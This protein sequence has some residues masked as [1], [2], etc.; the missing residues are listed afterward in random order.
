MRA[1]EG[2][3]RKGN[4]DAA[5]YAVHPFHIA[6]MLARIGVDEVVVQAAILHDVVEDCDGYDASGIESEFGPRV[7]G[8][9]AELTED[10]SLSW[11]TRKE[12]GIAKISRMS[13]DAV[14]VKAF[15]AMHNFESLR[16]ELER[17]TDLES[18]WN[19]FHGGRE[20]TLEIGRRVVAELDKR[21]EPRLSRLLNE[22]FDRLRALAAS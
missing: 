17:A 7:A 13:I 6:I 14:S 22:A 19:H 2:Q 12:A 4:G 16:A 21:L 20:G 5:P 8:I 9:V 10:T 1:H 3:V 15:D 18:V 11:R